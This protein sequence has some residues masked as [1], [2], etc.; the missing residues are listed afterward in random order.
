MK[1]PVK[2]SPCRTH[3]TT[4]GAPLYT[5]RFSEVL[6]F[7]ELGLAPVK[8][9]SGAYHIDKQGLPAYGAR[10]KR[11]FGFYEGLSAVES[12]QGAFHIR[13]DGK[14]AYQGYFSWCGNFQGGFSSVR[15]FDGSYCHINSSGEALL[16]K[17][18]LY[19]GDFKDSIAVVCN[20]EG[21]SSHINK[22]G[23]Y[24]HG[25]WFE[26][27]DVYHKGFARAKDSQGWFHI[28]IRG[29]E[30]YSE[31]YLDLEPFY[32][33]VA[34]AR[35][36]QGN[37]I[38]INEMGH[39]VKEI[40][41]K[42]VDLKGQLS[43]QLVGFWKSE[44]IR[45]AVQLGVLDLLPID[46]ATLAYKTKLPQDRLDRLFRALW[47]IGIV[48]CDHDK[49]ALS[50]QGKLLVPKSQ[51]HL[52]AASLMWSEI[53]K[54]WEGLIPKLKREEVFYQSTF[55]ENATDLEAVEVYQRAL[56]GYALEDFQNISLMVD[57]S[58][59]Y[60]VLGAGQTAMTVLPLLLNKKPHLQGMI[61]N[62]DAPLYEGPI[63][64][65]LQGRL[66]KNILGKEQSAICDAVLLP[67]YLH[68][69]PDLEVFEAL[70]RLKRYCA[71]KAKVYII[72]TLLN[73]DNPSGAL[74]DLN[75]LVESGGGLRTKDQWTNVLMNSAV[76][77]L[78]FKPIAE[79]LHLVE[80]QFHD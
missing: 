12:E 3:H 71:S 42:R 45:A 10:F 21:L 31:R 61:V 76:E 33:G 27:L 80:G 9:Q 13:P 60:Y 40:R 58:H 78:N 68:Y 53:H 77:V 23:D 19:V 65:E 2:V 28:D 32:N 8:D 75:M 57:W 47:E 17:T 1:F 72:E 48:F 44:V 7:H 25:R 67:R 70:K 34:H 22:K 50:D 4:G 38:L 6:K 46:I 11:T 36:P 51:S 26:Q 20:H 66:I 56:R 74:L 73:K 54:L 55:K 16:E 62:S 5:K 69:F 52:A 63:P 15:K 14:P 64:Q 18:F 59:H 39:I 49:W 79:H 29:Q 24:L 41:K 37:F 35:D 30:I 43:G